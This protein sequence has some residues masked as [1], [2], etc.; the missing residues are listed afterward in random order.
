MNKAI[1]YFLVLQILLLGFVGAAHAVELSHDQ[2]TA[3]HSHFSESGHHPDGLD[4]DHE[5]GAHVHFSLFVPLAVDDLAIIRFDSAWD[6][7]TPPRVASQTYSPP[8]P[9]PN[10]II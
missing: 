3:V 5:P 6:L 10:P 7:V 2:G 9:P 4:A 1:S 8:V